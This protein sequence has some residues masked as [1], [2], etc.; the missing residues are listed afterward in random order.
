MLK[1]ILTISIVLAVSS[2][3]NA[4]TCGFGCLGLS[5]FYGG[6][7]VE[8]YEPD[9]LNEALR[10]TLL[11]LDYKNS[12]MKFERGSGFRVGANIF[13]AN[14]GDYFITAKGFYQFLKEQHELPEKGSNGVSILKSKLELNHWG[15]G[16]DFGI[17]LLKFLNWKIVEGGVTFYT[18]ELVNEFNFDGVNT[19]EVKY[20][21]P[22]VE[23]GYYVGTGL[24]I[25]IIR[26]YVSVEGSAVYKTF[27]FD[28]LI[29]ENGNLFPTDEVN[30]PLI[31]RGG[32]SAT[33]QL[34]IGVPL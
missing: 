30:S 14:F 19:S 5:G 24:I 10:E 18:A 8:Y 33:V 12:P 17:P 22:D 32:L 15:V 28:E 6:Y 25:H 31:Q 7:S 26:D 34:N 2:V 11:E 29:D 1:K 16:V 13:R 20:D 27:K 21:Q 4:Q 23:V 3:I 9:G